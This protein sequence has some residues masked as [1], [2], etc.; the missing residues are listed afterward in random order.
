MWV[1]IIKVK[2]KFESKIN[3]L[4]E[5]QRLQDY[6]VPVSFDSHFSHHNWRKTANTNYTPL[7]CVMQ[8]EH[9]TT[10]ELQMNTH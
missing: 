5:V 8:D 9:S 7:L 1:T 4:A 2:F 10:Q 6:P 3:P